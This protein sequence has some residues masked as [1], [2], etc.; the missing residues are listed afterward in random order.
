LSSTV[1]KAK[2]V[3]PRCGSPIDWKERLK[4]K[5]G[6]NSYRYYIVAVHVDRDTGKRKKC[7]LGPEEGYSL[8]VITHVEHLGG[9]E[10][11]VDVWDRNKYYLENLLESF[12]K[13]QD[14]KV[15]KEVISII[16]SSL[17]KLE[18]HLKTLEAPEVTEVVSKWEFRPLVSLIRVYN[19][20]SK[21]FLL[22]VKEEHLKV[23]VD[24][25]N[26]LASELGVRFTEIPNTSLYKFYCLEKPLEKIPTLA[27]PISYVSVSKHEQDLHVYVS[28]TAYSVSRGYEEHIVKLLK[29]FAEN[30]K[31]EVKM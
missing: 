8:A 24:G 12:S 18:A 28:T 25:F 5:T 22:I 13:C 23:L 3:C 11:L 27:S 10:G 19:D 30:I 1:G 15:L 17:S 14:P 26:K 7:Y 20:G 16:K 21:E 2:E 4:V 6:A 31:A 9:L 29:E